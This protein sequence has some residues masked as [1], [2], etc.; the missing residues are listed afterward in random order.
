[1]Y[2]STYY[3]RETSEAELDEN[4]YSCCALRKDI[5]FGQYRHIMTASVV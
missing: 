5:N 4:W 1:M 2:Q 3:S